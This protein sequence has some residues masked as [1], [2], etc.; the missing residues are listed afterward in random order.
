VYRPNGF[1]TFCVFGLAA[2]CLVLL[3]VPIQFAMSALISDWWI[4]YH[5]SDILLKLGILW[6]IWRLCVRY[7][8]QRWAEFGFRNLTGSET[9]WLIGTAIAVAAATFSVIF[10]LERLPAEP[11]PPDPM[12]WSGIEDHTASWFV[13]NEV[14]GLLLIL[15][16]VLLTP[17]IEEALFR[18]V[19]YGYLSWRLGKLWAAALS[20]TAFALVHVRF[21]DG[22]LA[23]WVLT[24]VLFLHALV[25]VAAYERTGTLTAPVFLHAA[26]NASVAV[27]W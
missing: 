14:Y 25:F 15:S 9:V 19:L 6:I 1:Q 20:S 17:I 10:V 21:L 16:V 2:G 8:P 26:W 5:L 23:G 13:Q 4:G 12:G 24:C 11:V 7:L 27:S 22:S 18:G 3:S